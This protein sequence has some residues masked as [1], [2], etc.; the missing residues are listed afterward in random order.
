MGGKAFLEHLNAPTLPD[1]KDQHSSVFILHLHFRGQRFH[2]K[3]IPVACE[4]N[5]QEGFLFE[6]TSKHHG[7]ELM[8]ILILLR[9]LETWTSTVNYW[10]LDSEVGRAGRK[11]I[12][13]FNINT[14]C[15]IYLL[16]LETFNRMKWSFRL[17]SVLFEWLNWYDIE[18]SHIKKYFFGRNGILND[19]EALWYAAFMLSDF[20]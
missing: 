7:K 2:S 1:S 14:F 8:I 20:I 4:P 17:N 11:L 16:V 5:I 6:L 12:D 18:K 3:P 15:S 19:L 9:L 10:R 13:W